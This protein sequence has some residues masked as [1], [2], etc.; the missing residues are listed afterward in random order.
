MKITKVVYFTDGSSE[1]IEFEKPPGSH[2]DSLVAFYEGIK[3]AEK[4]GKLVKEISTV[5]MFRGL[6]L[7]SNKFTRDKVMNSME[8][9]GYLA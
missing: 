2:P 3:S 7:D 9:K 6:P 4:T 5:T 8:V 1:I